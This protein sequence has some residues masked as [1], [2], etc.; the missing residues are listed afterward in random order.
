MIVFGIIGL[1]L[2]SYALWLKNEK[3]QDVIFVI[4]GIS[5][6][7]YSFFIGDIIFVILQ[8]VFILSALTELIKL[9]RK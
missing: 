3:K 4:G 6:L 9:W 5:L 7:V 2:I 8:V 1:L